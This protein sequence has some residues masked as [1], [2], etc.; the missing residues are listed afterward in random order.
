MVLTPLPHRDGPHSKICSGPSCRRIR[1]CCL[2]NT[3]PVDSNS[4]AARISA[5]EAHRA[6]PCVVCGPRRPR[7]SAAAPPTSGNSAS[8]PHIHCGCACPQRPNSA[9]AS[10]GVTSD[11]PFPIRCVAM[12]NPGWPA[13]TLFLHLLTCSP[14]SIARIPGRTR[15]CFI[16]A[17]P[18]AFR[19]SVC[20][21]A[22]GWLVEPTF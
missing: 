2:P 22:S 17:A 21:T 16:A 12:W 6:E 1:P 3:T 5:A 20:P 15:S 9:T 11:P 7:A 13:S 18:Q 4:P 19:L 14:L 8:P 10:H